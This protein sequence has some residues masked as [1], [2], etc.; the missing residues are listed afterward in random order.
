VFNNR[1]SDLCA[2]GLLT[3]TG[4]ECYYKPFEDDYYDEII[5]V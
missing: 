1:N 5:T 3:T 4:E 2:A